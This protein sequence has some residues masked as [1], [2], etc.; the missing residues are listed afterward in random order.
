MR[1][2]WRVMAKKSGVPSSM[3]R[4]VMRE[5]NYTCAGCGLQGFEKRFPIQGYGYY[6]AIERV[7]LS[8]DH[9][10]PKSLGGSSERQNLR[11][12]CTTC[13]TKKGVRHA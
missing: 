3:R 11:V 9:I 6:T 7:Y 2:N 8:I 13:N 5:E 1:L 10:F 12:L 4:R